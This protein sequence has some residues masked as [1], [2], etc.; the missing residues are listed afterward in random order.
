[1]MSMRQK[2]SLQLRS[3]Q[4]GFTLIELVIVIIILGILLTVVGTTYRGVQAKNRNSQR[5]TAVTTLQG[6]LETYYAETSMYPTLADLNNASW[7]AAHMHDTPTSA[8]RDPSWS[9]SVKSCTSNSHSVLIDH[10]AMGCYSYQ[11]VS[12]DGSACDNVKKICAHYTLTA[13]LEGG[14]RFTKSSLN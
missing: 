13:D 4:S 5:E 1:M 3:T 11:P 14:S 10:P 9:T 2:R 7:V 12:N 8:L 6:G